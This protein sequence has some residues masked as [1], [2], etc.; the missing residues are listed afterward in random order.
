MTLF[1]R[2]QYTG[3][4]VIKL[5]ESQKKAIKEFN[6][7]D[8]EYENVSCII[9][10]SNNYEILAEQ[11]RIGFHNSVVICKVCGLIRTNPR[12][13]EQSYKKFYEIDYRKIYGQTDEPTE[14]FFERQYKGGK[15]IYDD[16]QR[17]IGKSIENKFIV[18]IGCA[19]GGNLQYFKEKNNKVYGVDYTPNYVEFGKKKGLDIEVGTLKNLEKIKDTP[20]IVIYNN[21]LEH[22]LNP[23]QELKNLRNFL[24]VDTLLYIEVSTLSSMPISYEENFLYFLTNAHTYHFTDDSLQNVTKKA[25]FKT[26]WRDKELVVLLKLGGTLNGYIDTYEQSINYLKWMEKTYS[27]KFNKYKI[28]RRLYSLGRKVTEKTKTKGIAKRILNI[29]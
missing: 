5:N 26:V 15:G 13:T 25:G 20:D 21:V 12:M 10:K 17:A 14:Q 1:D 24:S 9:C 7:K 27:S 18:E 11:D 23:I 19:S 22:I 29:K 6:Q 4:P 2:W 8:Y 3:V 28:Y 16:I